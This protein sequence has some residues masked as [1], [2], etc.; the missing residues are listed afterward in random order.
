MSAKKH[1]KKSNRQKKIVN[2]FAI[3][4]EM[5]SSVSNDLTRDT[6]EE[7]IVRQFRQIKRGY[8]RLMNEVAKEFDLLRGWIEKEATTRKDELKSRLS[9]KMP[10]MISDR[11]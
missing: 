7:Q 11:M 5:H 9:E 2:T 4:K 3:H 10:K 1:L 6:Q 8:L